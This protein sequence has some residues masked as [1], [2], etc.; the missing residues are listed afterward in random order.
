MIFN[1][2]RWKHLAVFIWIFHINGIMGFIEA[3]KLI[4][5]VAVG[6]AMQFNR[7]KIVLIMRLTINAGGLLRPDEASGLAMTQF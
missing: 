1:A 3:F 7:I 5:F 2:A 4:Q 6:K